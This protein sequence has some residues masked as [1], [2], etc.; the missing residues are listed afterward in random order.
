MCRL[1][2]ISITMLLA[3]YLASAKPEKSL[4]ITMS[5]PR[6][7][8]VAPE[9]VGWGY[10]QF[11]S[12]GKWSDGT[13]SLT[14]NISPDAAESYGKPRAALISNDQGKTWKPMTGKWGVGG[15][16]LPNGDRIAVATP[17][18]Y[19]VARLQLPKPA[20]ILTSSYSKEKYV[21]YRL[22]DLPPKLRTIRIIRTKRESEIGRLEHAWLDD[23][24][25]LRYSL[26]SIFPIVWWGDMHVLKDGSLIAIVYPGLLTDEDGTPHPKW[27]VFA[28]RST[29]FG[30][31]WKIQ[32]R[33]LY[34]PDIKADPR[35][36]ER[37][38][39]TEPGSLVMDDG[40]I[41]CVLRTTDGT[42]IG[43]MYVTRSSDMGKT[44]ST[45]R[46]IAPNGVLPRLLRLD[47]GILV[48]SSGRPG[49]QLRFCTDG[50]GLKWSEPFE[51][52]P[53][54]ESNPHADTCGYTSLIATGPDTFLIAY[55]HFKH[56]N[57]QGQIRKAILVREVKARYSKQ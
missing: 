6:V 2:V 38:G 5:E 8:A 29:D 39:F 52:I 22:Q 49:V 16:L 18:P 56:E 44:W 28:Y 47:N 13:L 41:I 24:L 1:G 26:R 53:I 10:Y 3:M 34:R 20:G 50:K 12:L 45:P 25:A 55:S 9:E 11:P 17:K 36:Q 33:I 27:H 30:H 32:G 35:G 14:Y 54:T 7:V 15:L 40:S 19:D 43:P 42:G 51:L 4:E 37:N 57:D 23:P 31:T 46:V 21:V 48:L